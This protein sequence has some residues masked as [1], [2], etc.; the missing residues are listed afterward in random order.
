LGMRSAAMLSA[1]ATK[2]EP[3]P[4]RRMA[5]ECMGD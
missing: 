5:R 2:L 3:R 1:M 4:E